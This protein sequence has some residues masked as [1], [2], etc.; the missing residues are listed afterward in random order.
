MTGH[1]YYFVKPLV[2]RASQIALRRLRAQ[3]QMKKYSDIWPIDQRAATLP[4]GWPGWPDGK[5]FALVLQHDVDTQKGHDKCRQLMNLEDS[6][7]VRSCFYI[8]PER[9][10]VSME[11]LDEIKRRRF[12]LGVHGLKHDGKL[13]FT[14]K[15]FREK[16]EQVN[17]YLHKWNAR[18][19]SA[20]SM[21]SRLEWMHHLDIDSSTST[22]DTDPFEPQPVAVHTIFPFIVNQESCKKSFVELPYSLP[23]DFTLFII[24]QEKTI[25]IWKKKLDWVAAHG[26]MALVNTHPDYMNFQKSR[27]CGR[28]EYPVHFYLDFIE[29]IKNTYAG[30]FWN[31]IPEE[32]AAYVKSNHAS[33][34]K[35]ECA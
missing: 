27:A 2:P 3:H 25:D 32:I 8:V 15:S 35:Q 19:F 24:L 29:Y 1:L 7:G 13:F 20:P 18:G 17:Q 28:E 33:P 12:G 16:A 14:Y 6:I 23:Q 21:I 26:G 9:Y 10:A 31:A 22:F 11:L 30:R 4:P 5:K 34:G